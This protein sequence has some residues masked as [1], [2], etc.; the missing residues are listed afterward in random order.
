[1]ILGAQRKLRVLCAREFQNSIAE[2]AHALLAQQ[3]DLLGLSHLYDTQE[4]R[5]LGTNGTEFIFKG[6][7]A[8]TCAGSRR[9]ARSRRRPGT[10]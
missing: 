5:I 6:P 10:C 3:I 2:S 4:K 8:W 7:R 1:V 9:P